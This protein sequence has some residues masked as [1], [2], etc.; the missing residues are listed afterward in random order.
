MDREQVRRWESQCIQEQAPACASAC[1]MHVDA[2]KLAECARKGDFK[3]GFSVLAAAVP[4]PLIVA[5]V[6]DHPCQR[7]C[8]R[9]DAGDP[10]RIH[11]LEKACA[12]FGG[13]SPTLRVQNKRN[14]EIL[15]C[16]SELSG[17][18]AAILLA[19]KGYNVTLH[20]PGPALLGSLRGLGDGF[21]PQM[22][23]GTDMAALEA[24][25]I[26]V[27]YDREL[28]HDEEAILAL[29]HEYDAL[30]FEAGAWPFTF[31]GDPATLATRHPGVFA[32]NAWQELSPVYAVYEGSVAAISIDRY[33]QGASLTANRE[34]RGAYPSRLYMNTQDQ[35]PLAAVESADPEQGYTRE[36]AQQE[37][38]RCF[39]CQCLECVKVCEYLKEYKSYPKRYVREIYNNEC[40][41]MGVRK[42]NRMI[43]SCALCGLCTTVCPENLSMAEVILAARRGMVETGKMPPSAHDL[44][45]RDM[46]FSTSDAFTLAR[47][48]PGHA[49]SAVAFLPGCQLSSSSPEHVESVYK[50]LRETTQGGVGL[51][52][53]CCG[54]PAQWAGNEAKFAE[55]RAE[56]TASWEQLGR[57]KLITAC[58]SCIRTLHDH[59]P[60]IPVESLWKHIDLALIAPP[61][62]PKRLAVHDP[63][64]TREMREV[65]D[66][67]RALLRELGVEIEELNERGLTTCCGFGGLQQFAN[68]EL[69]DRTAQRRAATSNTDYVTYCAMCRDRFSL[70][71]KRAVHILDLIFP[72][73]DGADPAA[74]L[75]PGFSRRQEGRARLKRRLLRDLWGE[76]EA[77]MDELFEL[78]IAEEV[79]ALLE[80]RMI[81]VED[82]RQAVEHAEKTG[83][84]LEQPGTGHW[85]AMW[86]P[87]CVTYWVEYSG[88]AG[89]F[90]VHNAYSHRMQ[91]K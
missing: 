87:S 60:Q 89:S 31:T 42:A 28:P 36:E 24:L 62:A 9:A 54:A 29:R 3:A 82:V 40:I 18:S 48:Q 45:L 74:R 27:C 86:R 49:S 20:E 72:A 78:E 59:L 34:N 41:V 44:A 39:P 57:P 14:R 2:R 5:Y 47:H 32:G 84:K 38:A 77:E 70:R 16:G 12:E 68:P 67:A 88:G 80:K 51:I 91:V 8:R 66:G 81:L 6:C 26:E 73:D 15:V 7:Q 79:R 55:A 64:S 4:V 25:E 69:A 85:L 23:I 30:F 46:A 35:I 43:N 65:E 75:D 50:H 83:E 17:V 37:A 58:S 61:T 90:T 10:I 21:L 13:A 1:P 71:G 76:T 53:A 22:A 63:C 52:L 19:Q 11:E 33:L 56:L